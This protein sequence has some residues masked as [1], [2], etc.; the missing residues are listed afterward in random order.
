MR[1]LVDLICNSIKINYQL[2]TNPTIERPN[3]EFGDYSTNVALQ[4]AGQVGKSPKEIAEAIANELKNSPL[5]KEVSVAG[6]GFINMRVS[7][8]SL[9]VDITNQWS[10]NYGSNSDGQGKTVVVEYP[11]PNMAKPYSVGHLRP[12]NQGWAIKRL[13]EESG[14]K[15]V[16]D[17]HLGDYGTPFGIWSVGF[18][19]F[20]S[21]EKLN[22]GGVNELGRIY[23][24]TKAALETEKENGGHELADEV[25][26]WL[27]KL[28][29]GDAEA[30]ALSERF[31]KIS[32]D[33]IHEIM[34]RLEISTDYEMGEAG[35]AAQAKDIIENL[36]NDGVA[37]ENADGSVVIELEGFDTPMLVQKSNGTLLYASTDIA[38]LLWR[39]DNWH[40]DRVIYCVGAEQQFHFAQLIALAKKLY[41]DT[42]LIHVWFGIIDQIN[43]DGKREKMSSRKGVVLMEELL[44]A[45]EAR[46]REIVMQREVSEDDIK[47]IALGAIKYSDFVADRRTNILFGW[48]KIFAL[49]GVSGP[50]V[51]YAA[52][53][54]NRVL[55]ENPVPKVDISGYDYQSEKQLLLKL[56]DYP[57]VVRLA[58]RDLEPHKV[59]AYL[60][61]LAREMNRYYEATPIAVGSVS[62][63]EK[64]ARLILLQKVAHVFKHGLSILGIRVPKSM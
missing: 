48:D 64:A 33:H 15:V 61:E 23:I 21:E 11:S 38:T 41:I 37:D 3:I 39:E 6:P 32:L 57:E 43:E 17:N 26:G 52:V 55:E 27:M 50:Y 59:A 2:E 14:W 44:D 28:D 29:G 13:M 51:Q 31:N 12:G 56:L 42:K 10:D 7:A 16:T 63:V 40:P 24:E 20:S 46:A 4:I 25:Q 53:R 9:E 58:S 8:K 60:Y 5:V 54:I 19:K 22:Q 49:N 36:I 35:F 62:E 18:K 30:K 34:K 45:A 47:T 1:Q